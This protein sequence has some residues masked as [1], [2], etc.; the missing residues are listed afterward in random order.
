MLEGIVGIL[1]TAF[2]AVVGW[3]LHLST[4]VSVLETQSEGLKE[5]LEV[6][7]DEVNRR[8]GRIERAMN[9]HLGVE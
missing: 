9:G 3:A 8:L 4:R 6:K 2:L 1:G 7:F 5:L